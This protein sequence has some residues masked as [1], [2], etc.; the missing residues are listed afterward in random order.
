VA[1]AEAIVTGGPAGSFPRATVTALLLFLAPGA[2]AAHHVGVYVPRDNDVSTNFKQLKFS[3]QAAK[4][5][6]A[7]RL[8][9]TGALR[10]E[11]RAQAGRLPAGLEESTRRAI[12]SADAR[13]AER[14]L[15]LF[16]AALARDLALDADRRLVDASESAEARVAAARKFLEAMWRYYNLVDFAVTQY[17]GKTGVAVRLAFDEAEGYTR[18]PAAVTAPV[19]VPSGGTGRPATTPDPAKMREP[20]RR[21]AQILSGLIDTTSTSSRRSS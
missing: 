7:A 20:F 12:K 19:S 10:T 14:C 17:D 13:G 11:M 5:D 6:V 18:D 15:M 16:F 1:S 2:A 9:E 4:F 8:F 3:I 21:I